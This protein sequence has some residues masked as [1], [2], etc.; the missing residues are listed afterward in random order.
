MSTREKKQLSEKKVEKKW[1]IEETK[2]E[3]ERL[4]Y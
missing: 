3:E 4:A 1:K 2:A